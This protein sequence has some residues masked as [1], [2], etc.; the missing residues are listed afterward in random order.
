MSG[1][2]NRSAKKILN[3]SWKRESHF[4]FIKKKKI[5]N[6]FNKKK[7]FCGLAL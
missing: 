3:F 6:L 2:V 5:V 4:C 1:F 7:G